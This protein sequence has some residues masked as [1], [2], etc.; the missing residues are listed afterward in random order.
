V[1]S[2]NIQKRLRK[3]RG[4]VN[5]ISFSA[6]GRLLLSGSDDRTLVLWDWQEAAPALSF[7]TGHS[8]NVYHALFMP[9]SGDRSIVSCAA[10]GE[11]CICYYSFTWRCPCNNKFNDLVCVCHSC[12]DSKQV[13]HS[14]IQEGGRVI[15]DKLVELEF[16]V[17]RLA[18]EPASPH[19][20][21]CCCQDSSVWLVCC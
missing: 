20:F 2:L 1:Q 10:D 6:D 15:T 16:A 11:V 5:T 4:C 14:Q 18:V 8:N 21:Y 13:I 17:H 7:H 12:M 9:V 3:H 19:T